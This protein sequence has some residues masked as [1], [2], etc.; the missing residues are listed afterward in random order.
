VRGHRASILVLLSVVAVLTAFA[1]GKTISSLA[2]TAASDTNISGQVQDLTPTPTETDASQ[3]GST[4]GI[5]WMGIAITAIVLLP[6][7]A[8]R[9]IWRRRRSSSAGVRSG[10]S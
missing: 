10:P 2:M 6:I 9:V 4:D 1:L 8:N 7:L 5:V 3:A